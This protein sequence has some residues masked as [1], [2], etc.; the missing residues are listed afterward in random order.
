MCVWVERER[1]KEESCSAPQGK[2]VQRQDWAWGAFRCNP[3][4][5]MLDDL[6]RFLSPM[7]LPRMW[8]WMCVVR[9]SRLSPA[10][11]EG[12]MMPLGALRPRVLSLLVGPVAR[13]PDIFTTMR[14]ST[15]LICWPV[16]ISWCYCSFWACREA[17]PT[18]T[19]PTKII[20]HSIVPSQTLASKQAPHSPPPASIVPRATLPLPTATSSIPV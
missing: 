14:P 10:P 16:V 3:H 18:A 7:G 1:G 19:G 13:L 20:S 6:W 15:S 9:W 17:S 5:R 8:M 12:S 11:G 4:L 2:R